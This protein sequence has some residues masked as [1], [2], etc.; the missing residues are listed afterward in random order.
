[1]EKRQTALDYSVVTQVILLRPK[2]ETTD[3]ALVLHSSKGLQ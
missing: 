2:A 3:R 1:M